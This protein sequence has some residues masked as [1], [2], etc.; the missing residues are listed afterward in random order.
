MFLEQCRVLLPHKS[1][2]GKEWK[3]LLTTND[4]ASVILIKPYDIREVCL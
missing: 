4:M 2:L 1:F 3:G